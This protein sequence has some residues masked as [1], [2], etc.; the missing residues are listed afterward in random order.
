MA[1]SKSWI[2]GGTGLDVA[3]AVTLSLLAM[4]LG[5]PQVPRQTHVY[6]AD[7]QLVVADDSA[8]LSML[9]QTL[10]QATHSE[11][12][13]VNVTVSP[14][15]R[16]LQSGTATSLNIRYTVRCG[17]SCDAVRS[18]L[19]A[20]TGSSAAGLAHA[21]AIVAA[22]NAVSTRFGFGNAVIST[23]AD[24]AATM[25]APQLVTITMPVAP[26]APT[27][28]TAPVPACSIGDVFVSEA[29][30]SGDPADYIEIING[31]STNC[32][33]VGFTLDDSAAQSDMIFGD[34]TIAAGGVWIGYRHGVQDS[35][36]RGDAWSFASGISD[37]GEEIHLCDAAGNCENVVMGSSQS[38]VGGGSA[39]CFTVDGTSSACYCAPTPGLIN[40]GCDAAPE[41]EPE[42]GCVFTGLTLPPCMTN[43]VYITEAHGSGSPA[44]YV[45][46]YNSG[47]ADCTL[48]CWQLDDSA[49]MSDLTFGDVTISAGGLWLG[50]RHGIQDVNGLGDGLSFNSGISGTSESLHL[51]AGDGTCL[52]YI[53][54]GPTPDNGDA[55]CFNAPST[56]TPQVSAYCSPSPG[57]LNLVAH[58]VMTVM[59]GHIQYANTGGDI[60]VTVTGTLGTAAEVQ[61]PPAF[62]LRTEHSAT[63]DITGIGDFVSMDVRLTGNDGVYI[64]EYQIEYGDPLAGGTTYNWPTPQWHDGDSATNP[65]T[66]SLAAATASTLLSGTGTSFAVTTVTGSVAN[67]ATNS[68]QYIQIWGSNG[69]VGPMLL[70]A[71]FGGGASDTFTLDIADIGTF[72]GLKLINTGNDGWHLDSLQADYAS[73]PMVWTYG[74]FLDGNGGYNSPH[75]DFFWLAEATTPPAAG[76]VVSTFTMYISAVTDAH[77]TGDVMVILSGTAGTVSEVVLCPGGG[78]ARSNIV[79]TVNHI[80]IGDLVDVTLRLVGNDGIHFDEI[81]LNLGGATEFTWVFDDVLANSVSG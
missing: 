60:F 32:S 67:S 9:H 49:G 70:S 56:S 21:A 6:A 35:S 72:I 80:P 29:H 76:E 63:V 44:D 28:P 8:D 45:E 79:R 33:M 18:S 14:S 69:F 17:Q 43:E 7:L 64:S 34:V 1:V 39:T 4:A 27:G 11:L 71:S 46:L 23:P 2:A 30:G 52:D 58:A 41:P 65:P 59:I 13:D 22:A 19:T 54:M 40:A 36:G 81:R 42:V 68:D 3:A 75:Q 5:L 50:Y 74:A 15:R 26:T 57:A 47:S 24:I 77:S 48:A 37:S 73:Q 78:T 10:A 62:D 61:L 53:S 20:L 66:R 12:A 31:G 38:M 16:Q 25:S 55:Q 51:C